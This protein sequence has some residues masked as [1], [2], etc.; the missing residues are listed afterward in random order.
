MTIFPKNSRV[1]FLGDSI[2]AACNWATRVAE[3]YAKELPQLGVKFKNSGVSGGSVGTMTKFYD[4][5]TAPFKPT[6]A[7][8]F[9]GVNDSRRDLLGRERT[10]ERDDALRTA[11]ENYKRNYTALLDK[12][13]ADGITPIIIT[14]APYAEFF[15]TGAPAYKGG[16]TLIRMYAEFN[17]EIARARGLDV[18][19]FHAR[20]SELYLDE[21]LYN[22]DRIHPNDMGHYRM[23][24]CFVNAQG[25]E[26]VPYRPIE[27]IKA[28][29][30]IGEW[31]TLTHLVRR[32][33]G[34]EW[35]LVKVDYHAPIGEKLAYMQKYV[36]EQRWVGT[37]PAATFEALSKEYLLYKPKE[38]EMVARISEIMENIYN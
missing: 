12:L 30:R 35:M 31:M 25:R 8:I 37:G 2:T 16:H 34:S 6:H 11:F 4:D 3:Y 32:L 18:I 10:E 19:D 17:R 33:Y 14:P 23:A 24:E 28:D 29:G 20:L 9:L 1:A 36:D 5:D 27:E 26:M 13:Q 22:P 21:A 7:C 15:D 38:A